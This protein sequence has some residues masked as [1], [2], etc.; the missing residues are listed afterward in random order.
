MV[1]NTDHM[2]NEQKPLGPMGFVGEYTL[3]C[4]PSRRF[5]GK[6]WILRGRSFSP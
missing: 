1:L 6:P 4:P 2:S 3:G 5:F